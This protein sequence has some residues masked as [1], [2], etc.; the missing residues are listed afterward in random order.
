MAENRS[1]NTELSAINTELTDLNSQIGKRETELGET[2][3]NIET[4]TQ[5]AKNSIGEQ[6][7]SKKS[8]YE[9][10]KLKAVDVAKIVQ[11]Y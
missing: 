7:S 10:D 3:K 8:N 6:V 5:S 2:I 4:E 1:L 9:K 11:T